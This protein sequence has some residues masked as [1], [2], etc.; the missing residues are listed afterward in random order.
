MNSS[1]IKGWKQKFLGVLIYNWVP[2]IETSEEYLSFPVV[3]ASSVLYWSLF[4]SAFY[5]CKLE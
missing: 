1:G 4:Y 5:W 2:E 3:T